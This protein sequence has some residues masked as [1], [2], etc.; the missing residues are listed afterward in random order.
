MNYRELPADWKSLLGH[1]NFGLA[2]QELRSFFEV[3]N[4]DAAAQGQ[5]VVYRTEFVRGWRRFA[6]NPRFETAVEF[7]EGAP[8]YA[9]MLFEYFI[10]CCPNGRFAVY[11]QLLKKLRPTDGA[12]ES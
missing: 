5:A 10:E 11:D 6:E 8:D 9:Q 3:A 1:C 12:P 7:I 2:R 4:K